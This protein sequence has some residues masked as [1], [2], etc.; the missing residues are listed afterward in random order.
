MERHQQRVNDQIRVTPIRV[1]AS[2]GEQLGILSTEDAMQRLGE[3]VSSS[4]AGAGVTD[5][6]GAQSERIR[7]MD[8]D[9]WLQDKVIYGTPEAVVDR[10]RQLQEDLGLD[11][12]IYEVNYGCQIP[13]Q[14][15]INCL[16][17]LTEKVIPHF[18]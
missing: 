13:H 18:K 10:L 8:Y 16:R 3:I 5:D 11:R 15:Q 1:I 7:S 12:I 2:D 6:R 4:A 14:L 9:D 17:L